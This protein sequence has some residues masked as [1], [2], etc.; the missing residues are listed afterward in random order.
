MLVNVF[1]ACALLCCLSIWPFASAMGAPTIIY[2]ENFNSPAFRGTP[3]WINNTS[4]KWSITNYYL[5]PHNYDNWIFTGECEVATNADGSDGAILL[6]E[7]LPNTSA[8]TTIPRLTI[9]KN[10]VLQFNEWGDNEPGQQYVL[11]VALNGAQV[12]HYVGVDGTAGSLPDGRTFSIPFVATSANEALKFSQASTTGASPIIDNVQV[13]SA[14]PIFQLLHSFS[15]DPVNPGKDGALPNAQL[16]TDAQGNLYGATEAGGAYSCNSQSG[17]TV[18]CG[19]VFE[20]SPPVAAGGSWTKKML[21]WFSSSGFYPQSGLTPDQANGVF[22]GTTLYGGAGCAPLGCGVVYALT[23][24]VAGT[25]KKFTRLHVFDSLRAGVSPAPRLEQDTAGNLYGATSSGGF[26]NNG[27]IFELT[28]PSASGGRW[29]YAMLHRFSGGARGSIPNE[30]IRGSGNVIF[31]TTQ[32]GGV[33]NL[34]IVYQLSPPATSGGAWVFTPIHAFAGGS[35]GADPA[36]DMVIDSDNTLY[37]T[38]R[39][40]G[41]TGCGGAGCGAVFKLSPPASPGGA[42]TEQILYAFQGGSDG[43]TPE[44]TLVGPANRS[45][46][47]GTT[48]AGGASNLGTVFQLTP[49]TSGTGAWTEN[50]LHAFAGGAHDGANM[51]G[52]SPSAGLYM[53]ANGNLFGT[54]K[55]GGAHNVGTVYEIIP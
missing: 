36:G 7:G 9:G 14:G 42:W 47:Y 52:A 55:A 19:T 31:G 21:R 30:F 28:A 50:R 51:A 46:L 11:N 17:K 41:G 38:T 18:S 16:A 8:S 23:L 33:A 39:S 29:S 48:L 44:G 24:P 32:S 3:G 40:G 54:T 37:G 15:G 25:A 13:T 12:L 20:L 34:G 10:Y 2:S 6:N 49:P 1:R 22:Y 5:S 43:A 35:D 4:E 27:V 26:N 45:A 53:D